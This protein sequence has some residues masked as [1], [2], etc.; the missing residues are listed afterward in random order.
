MQFASLN[1]PFNKLDVR[2]DRNDL[3]QDDSIPCMGMMLQRSNILLFAYCLRLFVPLQQRG[4][5]PHI[6]SSTLSKQIDLP[7][8]E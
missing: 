4:I 3:C 1:G 2:E 5:G 7:L 6:A 8:G